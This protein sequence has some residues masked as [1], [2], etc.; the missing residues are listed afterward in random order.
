[1]RKTSGIGLERVVMMSVLVQKQDYTRLVCLKHVNWWGKGGLES[2]DESTNENTQTSSQ[3][4]SFEAYSN[5]GRR[6]LADEAWRL[7]FF[8]VQNQDW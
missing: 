1:M 5:L 6:Q 3:E 7:S 2:V 4:A 8:Q